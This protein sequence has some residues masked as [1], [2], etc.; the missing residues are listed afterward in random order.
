MICWPNSL[1]EVEPLLDCI[2]PE[3]QHAVDCAQSS[4]SC[5]DSHLDRCDEFYD[6]NYHCYEEFLDGGSY[7]AEG[8]NDCG[9]D[10]M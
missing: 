4:T 5:D 8:L 2:I 3:L 7:F 9:I 6:E 1:S 10:I